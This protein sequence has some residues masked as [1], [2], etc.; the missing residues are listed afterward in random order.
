MSRIAEPRWRGTDCHGTNVWHEY[1]M[2]TDDPALVK[3]VR[4]SKDRERWKGKV[5]Q[6]LIEDSYKYWLCYPV[7]NR[8]RLPEPREVGAERIC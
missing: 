6:I 7:I 2:Q 8:R 5:Y 4:E 1:I 3:R